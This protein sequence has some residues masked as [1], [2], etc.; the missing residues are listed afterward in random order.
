MRDYGKVS[1]KFWTGRTGKAIKAEGMEAVLVAMYLMTS[2][3]ADMLGV[4]YLPT[5][6]IAHDTGL[7][8]AGAC[9]G[10]DGCI[11]AGFGAGM[12]AQDGLVS[13]RRGVAT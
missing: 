2:P 4:Y 12:G 3:H 13:D 9:K 8:L 7:P 1:P 6:Y 10:L 11:K 5:V